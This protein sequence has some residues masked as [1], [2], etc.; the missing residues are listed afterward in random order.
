MC[1]ISGIAPLTSSKD[2]RDIISLVSKIKHRGPDQEKIFE[3]KLGIF[4]FV[5]LKIIDMSSD[6]NQPFVSENKK[7]QIL[8]LTLGIDS[9]TF[10]S[11]QKIAFD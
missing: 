3:N 8:V 9:T 4:G 6:S 7:I 1:G 2:K 11:L 5:R 10:A